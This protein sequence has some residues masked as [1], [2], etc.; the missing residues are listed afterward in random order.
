MHDGDGGWPWWLFWLVLGGCLLLLCC[1]LVFGF[2]FWRGLD[3]GDEESRFLVKA[4][5]QDLTSASHHSDMDGMEMS[6]TH[7]VLRGVETE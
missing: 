7:H 1:C 4:E 3:Q 6:E 2:L 5:S